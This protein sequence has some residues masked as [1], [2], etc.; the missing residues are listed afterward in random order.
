MNILLFTR[1][2]GM[3]LIYCNIYFNKLEAIKKHQIFQAGNESIGMIE[4]YKS[5]LDDVVPVQDFLL[6]QDLPA[7]IPDKPNKLYKKQQKGVR[8]IKTVGLYENFHNL[9]DDK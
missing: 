8:D 7:Q 4:C 9:I 6:K 5:N 2:I 3:Y 1:L